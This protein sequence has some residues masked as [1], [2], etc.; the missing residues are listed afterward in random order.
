MLAKEQQ[1]LRVQNRRNESKNQLVPYSLIRTNDSSYNAPLCMSN[2]YQAETGFPKLSAI[3]Y[4][5]WQ[6]TLGK[7]HHTASGLSIPIGKR[8]PPMLRFSGLRDN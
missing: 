8:I 7:C 4:M 6:L 3:T 2:S 1:A 5:A